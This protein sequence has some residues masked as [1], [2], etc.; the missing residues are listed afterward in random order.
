MKLSES[1]MSNLRVIN[2]KNNSI[3]NLNGKHIEMKKWVLVDKS[4]DESASLE[5]GLK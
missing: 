1:E 5:E 3:V 2:D 4:E